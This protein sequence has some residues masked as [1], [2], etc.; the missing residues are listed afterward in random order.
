MK[1]KVTCLIAVSAQ[2]V[3]ALLFLICALLYLPFAL[4]AEVI[5]AGIRKIVGKTEEASHEPSI[6]VSPASLTTNHRE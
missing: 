5:R 1:R 3:A 2:I 6:S 4:V